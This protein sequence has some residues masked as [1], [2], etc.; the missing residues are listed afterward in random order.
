MQTC[1]TR[2][3]MLI[4]RVQ[5]VKQTS[6]CCYML[7]RTHSFPQICTIILWNDVV[8]TGE[9]KFTVECLRQTAFACT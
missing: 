9:L 7:E 3:L 6:M 5:A 8:S 1:H 2:D 4:H